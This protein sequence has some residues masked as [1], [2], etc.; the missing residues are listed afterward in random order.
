MLECAPNCHIYTVIL[1]NNTPTRAVAWEQC[2]NY[3][4]YDTVPVNG[5]FSRGWG[6]CLED[7][8][9]KYRDT[10]YEYP[11]LPPG[12]MYDVD[13][14][15]RLTYGQNSSSCGEQVKQCYVLACVFNHCAI[16]TNLKW[17]SY[18]TCSCHYCNFVKWM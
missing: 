14:Q 18:T 11:V 10:D 2:N 15:C 12:T 3:H 5:F 9:A 1:R 16:Q 7:E 13:H 8:P 6:Y 17:H 4:F